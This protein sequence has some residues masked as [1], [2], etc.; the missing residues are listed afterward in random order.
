MKFNARW[1]L[2]VYTEVIKKCVQ[3]SLK[4]SAPMQFKFFEL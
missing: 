1:A 2:P 4:N 3:T